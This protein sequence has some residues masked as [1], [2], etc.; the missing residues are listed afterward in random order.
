VRFYRKTL[1]DAAVSRP[2]IDFDTGFKMAAKAAGL[3]DNFN[4]FTDD[5]SSCSEECCLKTSA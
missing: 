2:T 5:M 1:G 4:A 3:G